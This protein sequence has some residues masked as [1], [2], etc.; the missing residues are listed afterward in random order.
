MAN[1]FKATW[2]SHSSAGDFLKCPKSYYYRN[3]YKSPT[4]NKK[5][6][7]VSPYLSLGV[8]VHDVLEPLAWIP[9]AERLNVDFRREFLKNYSAFSGKKGGFSSQDE[10]EDFKQR[11]LDMLANVWNNPGPL[12]N[13][14]L[15]LSKSRDDL[16]WI[17]LSEKDEIILCGKAD[18]LE[19]KDGGS[20][21]IDFKT[22]NR[23]EKDDSLQL[24]IYQILIKNL[25]KT[26]L[27]GAA[28]WYI[29]KSAELTE[30]SLPNFEKSLD[31]VTGTAYRIKEARS[32]KAF[33]CPYGGCRNCEPYQRLINGEGEFLGFGGF[34][35]ELY[36]LTN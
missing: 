4:S 30:K 29:A 19:Y 20:R 17:W 26:P 32:A 13:P 7:V 25:M 5:I 1:K 8:A 33:D 16:P 18:W 12:L 2:I 9:A 34:G 10:E 22:G 11:G 23:E 3:V 31:K 28:Y 24:P 27:I 36:Y 35:Q 15:R 21:V 6:S 14:S